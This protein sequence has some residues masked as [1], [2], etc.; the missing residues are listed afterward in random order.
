MI[1]LLSALLLVFASI[2]G[3]GAAELRLLVTN[4]AKPVIA[5]IAPRFESRT[6]NRLS[7]LYEGSAALQ[8]AIAESGNF[9]V[10]LLI[11]ANMD[12][13]AKSG[14]IDSAS[15]TSFA[16]SGLG[17]GVRAGQPKPDITTVDAFRRALLDAKSVAYVTGGAS[18]QYFIALCQRLGIADQIKAKSKTLSTGSV[19]EFVV[20]G[21]AE[22]AI[23]QMSEVLS[24]KGI[25][26]VGPFPPEVDLVSRVDVAA[27]VKPSA[28][29]VVDQFLQYLNS[30]EVTQVIK[31]KGLER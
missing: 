3:I 6:G 1:K 28:P 25:D 13:V 4:G 20:N 21:E 10:A 15:R 16:R 18:G 17:V 26:L 14:R 2:E 9:D 22:L 11:S 7:I 12:A 27:A 31:S 30:A 8:K 24:V 23:Q 5:E 19:A 29:E